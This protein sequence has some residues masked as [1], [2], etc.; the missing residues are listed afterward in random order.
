MPETEIFEIVA[1]VEALVPDPYFCGADEQITMPLSFHG[2]FF[3]F[4]FH[5]FTSPYHSL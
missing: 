5:A 2:S 4:R 3:L 1:A